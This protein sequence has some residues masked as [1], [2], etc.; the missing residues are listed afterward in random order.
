MDGASSFMMKR[1]KA[2]STR[3]GRVV[4]WAARQRRTFA[5]GADGLPTG[6][7]D[8]QI[9]D[10][11]AAILGSAASRKLSAYI[12]VICGFSVGEWPL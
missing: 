2:E 12:C 8:R 4:R 1:G 3:P 7:G 5:F 9:A 11:S 10:C 6:G